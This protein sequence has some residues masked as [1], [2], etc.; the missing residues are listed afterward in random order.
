MIN[1]AKQKFQ[2]HRSNSITGRGIEFDLTFKEWNDWW[3]SHGVNKQTD[4]R[5]DLC[6]CR[7]ND[8]GPYAL[9]NIYLGTRSRNISDSFKNNRHQNKR[10][11]YT[12]NY[13]KIKTP[14]GIFN[15]RKEAATYFNVAPEAL[16]YRIKTKPQ[17]YYYI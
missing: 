5:S 17:E 3:L 9:D 14:L 4:K 10:K 12:G 2:T 11:D 15:S 6:M 16:N 13:K 7:F 8:T 1:I